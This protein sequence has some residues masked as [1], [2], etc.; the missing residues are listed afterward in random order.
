M[1]NFNMR[2]VSILHNFSIMFK[3]KEKILGFEKHKSGKK[4]DENIFG[5]RRLYHLQHRKLEKAAEQHVEIVIKKELRS[6]NLILSHVKD[7]WKLKG[8]HISQKKLL[9]WVLLL[10]FIQGCINVTLFKGDF[11]KHPK[12]HCLSLYHLTIFFALSLRNILYSYLSVFLTEVPPVPRIASGIWALTKYIDR[13]LTNELYSFYC[14]LQARRNILY[15]KDRKRDE[16]VNCFELFKTVLNCFGRLKRYL[17]D[18]QRD[19][20]GALNGSLILIWPTLK[21]LTLS[22][23]LL[24]KDFA[25]WVIWD[26]CHCFLALTHLS[27]P[28]Y[29]VFPDVVQTCI[30]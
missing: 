19:C 27:L 3:L 22:L 18:I 8:T 14:F 10:H 5:I 16:L 20:W 17:R 21:V 30:K 24:F 1:C 11:P 15:S 6:N 13:W 9:R 25:L 7:T 23:P 4:S 2:K 28:F 29:W 12:Q 26:L